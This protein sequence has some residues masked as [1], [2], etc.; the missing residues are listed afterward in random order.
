M[1][2]MHSDFSV[3]LRSQVIVLP[4]K[5]TSVNWDSCAAEQLKVLK[6]LLLLLQASDA[7][8]MSMLL[9]AFAGLIAIAVVIATFYF[10]R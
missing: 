8:W 6:K 7:L 10:I 2:L 5:D 9:S 1:V 3:I 4:L